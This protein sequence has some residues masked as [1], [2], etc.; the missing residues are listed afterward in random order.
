MNTPDGVD[1]IPKQSVKNAKGRMKCYVRIDD[2]QMFRLT[3]VSLTEHAA[4]MSMAP[5]GLLAVL[6]AKGIAPL[7]TNKKRPIWIYRL[8]DMPA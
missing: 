7:P 6:R 8:A 4:S 2:L 3:H 5:R 1:S